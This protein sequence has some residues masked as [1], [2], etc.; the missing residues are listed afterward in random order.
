MVAKYPRNFKSPGPNLPGGD[1]RPTRPMRPGEHRPRP[2]KLEPR[3]PGGRPPPPIPKVPKKLRPKLPK[4]FGLASELVNTPAGWVWNLGAAAIEHYSLTMRTSEDVIDPAYWVQTLNCLPFD[5]FAYR[6]T[7]TGSCGN[8]LRNRANFEAGTD[9]YKPGAAPPDPFSGSAFSQ[10]KFTQYETETLPGD[11]V[12]LHTAASWARKVG[13]PIPTPIWI[14]GVAVPLPTPVNPWDAPLEHPLSPQPDR[15]RPKPAAPPLPWQEPDEEQE[16]EPSEWPWPDPA[17]WPVPAPVWEVPVF[18]WP[19][20]LVPVLPDA[21]TV[22]DTAVI[23]SPD[24]FADPEA[25]PQTHTEFTPPGSLQQVTKY[26]KNVKLNIVMVA[27]KLWPVI[28]AATEAIDFVEGVYKGLPKSCQNRYDTPADK[29]LAIYNCAEHLDWDRVVQELLNQQIEDMIYGKIGKATGKATRE[30]GATTGLNKALKDAGRN[31]YDAG[32]GSP[33]S[34]L[35][36]Q[37]EFDPETG[38]ATIVFGS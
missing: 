23:T 7:G 31:Q 13:A 16:E 5:G 19:V 24:P 20:M 4:S 15:P 35:I 25:K 29:M 32:G 26:K 28:N 21:G 17:P 22:P 38:A 6:A 37:V 11:R 10:W 9:T 34:E 27:G 1:S 14:P 3:G 18:P 33:L 12:R 2:R 36:P 8:V 30:I